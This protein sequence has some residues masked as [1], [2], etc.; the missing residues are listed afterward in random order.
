MRTALLAEAVNRP[1]DFTQA[2][3]ELG[4]T[5]CTPRN[6]KC[7]SCP[8]QSGCLARQKG[9][10]DTLPRKM[11]KAAKPVRYGKVFWLVNAKGDFAIEKRQSK[12]LYEGMYQLPTTAW[13]VDKKAAAALPL[14]AGVA[15]KLLAKQCGTALPISI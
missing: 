11:A 7:G 8:W 2:F 10:Q 5:V 15:A 6:P 14:P 12:G 13:L 3:M 1:G 4:A 9:I